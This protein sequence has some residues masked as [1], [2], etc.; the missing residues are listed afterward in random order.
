MTGSPSTEKQQRILFANRI[1]FFDFSEQIVSVSELRLELLAHF[2]SNLV[3]AGVDS[4]ADNRFN[5]FG[6]CA[7]PTVHFSHSFFHNAFDRPAPTRVEHS[8][9]SLL[10]ICQ[11][12]RKAIGGLDGKENV[13]RAGDEAIADQR[14][15][16]QLIHAVNEIGVD[17]AESDERPRLF[18]SGGAELR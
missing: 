10:G 15:S 8:D 5:I 9:G 18:T 7:E 16:R 13:G 6:Q 11:D 12:D 1:G 4:R 2:G 3:A 17:L 14:F